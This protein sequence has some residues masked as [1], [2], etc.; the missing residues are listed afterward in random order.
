MLR[1]ELDQKC[2][3]PGLWHIDN[4]IVEKRHTNNWIIREYDDGPIMFICRRLSDAREWIV[5]QISP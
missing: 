4:Y 5:A 2:V 3:R 1:V